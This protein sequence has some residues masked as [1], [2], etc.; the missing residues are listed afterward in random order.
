MH[1]TKLNPLIVRRAELE[2]LDA[3]M[4]I[5][6]AAWPSGEGMRAERHKLAHR[7]ERRFT[8]LVCDA[9]GAVLGM[10]SGFR[11]KWACPEKLDQLLHGCPSRI[12]DQP[13]LERWQSISR[14]FDLPRDWHGATTEGELGKSVEQDPRGRVL[15]AIGLAIRPELGGRGIGHFMVQS[16]LAEVAQSGAQYFLA[17]GRLPAF[18]QFSHIDVDEYLRMT[19]LDVRCVRPLDPQ[20]RFYWKLGAQPI[21]SDDGRFRYVGIP[22]AMRDDPQCRGHGLLVAAP[23]GATPFSLE[24]L[25][26]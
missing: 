15:Y 7:I 8:W 14:E 22:G 17:Y 13:P 12:F 9:R 5:E 2:D 4:A 16:V 25:S 10:F 26:G 6:A 21:Q 20:L 18:H 1:S 24:R 3:I 19:D 11:P 23:I